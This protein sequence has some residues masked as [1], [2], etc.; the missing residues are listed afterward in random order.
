M[1]GYDQEP[2]VGVGPWEVR[3]SA[4][5]QEVLSPGVE[6]TS[7]LQE[8]CDADLDCAEWTSWFLSCLVL[9]PLIAQGQDKPVWSSR[10]W[11]CFHSNWL[12]LLWNRKLWL[13][14][15]SAGAAGFPCVR[16]LA[17]STQ[18]IH[19]FQEKQGEV[20]AFGTKRRFQAEPI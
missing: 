13:G 11:T 5:V 18:I 4:G 10:T 14:L 16:E 19:R 17:E 15:G 3:A 1:K 7:T 20:T 9:V 8:Q 12:E 6:F 2:V